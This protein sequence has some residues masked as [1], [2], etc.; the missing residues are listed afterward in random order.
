IRQKGPYGN[1]TPILTGEAVI[2]DEP[3]AVLWGDEFIY[4]KPP[5]LK[6]MIVISIILSIFGVLLTPFVIRLI[7]GDAYSGSIFYA[8]LLFAFI[9]LVVPTAPTGSSTVGTAIEGVLPKGFVIVLLGSKINHP[10]L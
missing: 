7:Y 10:P 8:Q 4:S 5:R 3:F 1:G 9:W 2:E 6:Q